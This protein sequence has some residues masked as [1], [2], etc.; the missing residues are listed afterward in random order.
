MTTPSCV[1]VLSARQRR[2][3]GSEAGPCGSR[4]AWKPIA[5]T[6]PDE[7]TDE[8]EE[9]HDQHRRGRDRANVRESAGL[10]RTPPYAPEVLHANEGRGRDD[11]QREERAGR[12][13]GSQHATNASGKDGRAE[14]GR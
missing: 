10:E 4:S 3:S 12:M 1:A 11:S 2:T 9:R 8:H 6:K 13:T 14:K 5:K 7:A